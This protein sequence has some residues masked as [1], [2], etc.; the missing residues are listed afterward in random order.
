MRQKNP[1]ASVEALAA[2]ADQIQRSKLKGPKNTPNEA[3]KTPKPYKDL[4]QNLE[5]KNN[6]T[7]TK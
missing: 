1:D 2:T 5:P 3:K 6:Q 7:P 4:F